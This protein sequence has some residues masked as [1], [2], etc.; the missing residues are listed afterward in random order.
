MVFS[1]L[2]TQTGTYIISSPD[3]QA[4]GLGLDLHYCLFW[5]ASLP[6]AHLGTFQL[7]NLHEPIPYTKPL[8]SFM[9]VCGYTY[10]FICILLVLFLWRTE[11]NIAAD[12]SSFEI[13]KYFDSIKR[14]HKPVIWYTK[15][16]A[17]FL[18]WSC[19]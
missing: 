4:I 11:T 18:W 9:C 6:R 5:V 2:W 19:P 3:P 7:P 12:F 15:D 14:Y 17:S 8:L 16:T 1:S 13:M 10:T